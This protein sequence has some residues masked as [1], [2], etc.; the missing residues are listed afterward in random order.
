MSETMTTAGL[1]E[2]VRA[3]AYALWESEGRP[4]GRDTEHWRMCEEEARKE[5]ERFAT[6]KAKS[7][8]KPKAAPGKKASMKRAAMGAEAFAQA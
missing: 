4:F 7:Q 6:P 2:I 1:D 8:S 3:R 5:L